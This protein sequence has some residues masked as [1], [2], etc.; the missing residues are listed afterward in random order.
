MTSPLENPFGGLAMSVMTS[1]NALFR[2][3]VVGAAQAGYRGIG[4]RP[5]DRI[6]ALATG[7]SDADLRAMLADNG[8]V[9]AEIDVLIGWGADDVAAA[10][11]AVHEARIYE[12]VDA[13][14]GA[15]HVTVTGD[16]SGPFERTVEKFA[17]VCDRAAEHDLLV[18]LEFLPWTEVPDA[19][20]ARSIIEATDRPNGGVLIDSWHHFRGAASDDQLRA[21]PA[22]MVIGIQFD[23][24]R[25]DA[26]G[27]WL[28]QTFE[29]DLPGEG[30]F[31]LP[32]FLTVLAE[33]GV[34]EPICVEVINSS[35]GAM[36]AAAAAKASFDATTAV[37][38]AT[39]RG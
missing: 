22:E 18:A 23:D 12:L 26:E 11:S 31:D 10:K 16:L 15:H 19:D 21:V 2:D 24:G 6:K 3:R 1:P 20:T 34:T 7:L 9:V 29:R 37:L 25:F 4:L 27:T 36:T 5:S 14:G 28:E 38:Q 13:V 30:Q 39:F 17:G 33:M 32:H 8:L 35:L